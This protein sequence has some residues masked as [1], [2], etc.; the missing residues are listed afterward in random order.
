MRQISTFYFYTMQ[1]NGLGIMF[2]QYLFSGVISKTSN[3][4][5]IVKTDGQE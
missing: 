4:P 5:V 2:V 3:Q 1:G